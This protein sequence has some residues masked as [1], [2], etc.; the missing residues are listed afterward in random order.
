MNW[1]TEQIAAVIA[2]NF[3][4]QDHIYWTRIGKDVLVTAEGDRNAAVG[5][6]FELLPTHFTENMP[7]TEGIYGSFI[8]GALSEVNWGQI[9]GL[10][11]DMV[12]DL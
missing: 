9:A 11:I 10:I 2:G 8:T 5:K 4:E 7:V 12:E 3:S 1:E 6:L